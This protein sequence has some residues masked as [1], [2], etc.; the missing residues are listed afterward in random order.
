M[1]AWAFVI[2]M[3]GMIAGCDSATEHVRR[4]GPVRIVVSVAP[5]DGLVRALAPQDAEVRCLAPPGGSP[6][7]HEMTPGDLAALGDADMV[8]YVGLGI[9]RQV[10]AFLR[11][12]PRVGRREVCFAAVAW[13]APERGHS[14]HEGQEAH[15]GPDPHLWLDPSLVQALV[16][17]VY[18]AMEGM[19]GARP[20]DAEAET[21]RRVAEMDTRY[22][23]VLSRHAGASIVTQHNAFSRLAGRYGLTIAAVLRPGESEEPTPGEVAAAVDAVRKAGARALFVEPQYPSASAQAL[24]RQVGV[25]VGTLDAEGMTDWFA[26]MER[27][28]NELVRVLAEPS[29]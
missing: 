24:A 2:L 17:A 13:V 26:L 9:D 4:P 27:N 29:R 21:L 19:Q 16:V 6:H 10:G 18:G 25:P 23:E 28:L 14:E 15:A 22:S 12:H 5:L 7:G 11:E 3:T 1:R 8:V 20:A